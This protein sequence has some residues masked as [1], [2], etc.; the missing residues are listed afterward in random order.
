MPIKDVV[1]TTHPADIARQAES[2]AEVKFTGRQ[3]DLSKDLEVGYR[4]ERA[5]SGMDLVAHR[6]KDED[7]TFM[8]LLT[9][10][11]SP[12]RL[13]KDMT[14]VFDTSGSMEGTRI[15]QAKAALKFCLSKLQ[16]DDRFNVLSFATTVTSFE[17]EHLPADDAAKARAMKFVDAFDAS[18]G[19]NINDALI[20]ALKHKAAAGRPHLI[21][22]LTDGEPTTGVTLSADILRNV[23]AANS[24]GR[25][26]FTFG[27]GASLNCGLLE[28]LADAT[29]A[30][31]EFV[32]DQRTSRRKCRGSRRRSPRP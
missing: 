15:R 16:P 9:P 26:H 8:L 17:N 13:P 6:P 3:I 28:D 21:L 22:F 30:V 4:I 27:V 11:A 2:T 12:V 5:A 24:A 20:R 1:C 7:G 18:G 32:S 10:T 19:T 25:P 14:F 23:A 29:H 31:A